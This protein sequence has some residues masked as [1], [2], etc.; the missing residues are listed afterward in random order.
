M[1]FVG[2]EDLLARLLTGLEQGQR[3]RT[4]DVAGATGMGKSTLLQEAQRRSAARSTGM[5]VASVDLARYN[6]EARGRG[7]V[8]QTY[9]QA[10]KHYNEVRALAS[11]LLHDLDPERA[12]VLEET[13]QEF[14]RNRQKMKVGKVNVYSEMTAG[15]GALISA[16]PQ[17]IKVNF[18]QNAAQDAVLV[19]AAR[20]A[21]LQL[22]NILAA[23]L[24]DISSSQ[25][26]LLLFDNV[27]IVAGQELG[28]WISHLISNLKG[29]V[30]VL[31]HEP[32]SVLD[33]P[34]GTGDALQISPF[35]L[36]EVSEF[37]TQ[38]LG[39]ERISDDLVA[40]LYKWS[41][42]VPIALQV[43]VDLM[44]DPTIKLCR[45]DLEKRLLR[46][47]GNAE[48]RLAGVVT[49]MVERLEG[50]PLGKALR[51]ASI[52]AECDIKLLAA[53][54][55]D[56]GVTPES[57]IPL[58]KDLEAFSFTDE[59]KSPIDK[60]D[61]VKVH[62]F[63]RQGIAD[64]MLKY[65]PHE[66]NHLHSVAAEYFYGQFT[67]SNSYFEMFGFEKPDQQ[68]WLRKW[69]Y[70]VAHSEDRRTAMLQ[71][72]RV[73]FDAFWWWGNYVNF[74]FC[75]ILITDFEGL[76]SETQDDN[77]VAFADAVR[78]F[79]DNYPYR[80]KLRQDFDRTY[81]AAPWNEVE[82]ALFE[83]RELCGLTHPSTDLSERE[84]H[85]EALLQV[86]LAHAS[87]YGSP[88]DPLESK[89][90][91]DEAARHFALVDRSWDVP[92]VVFERGDLALESGD[93]KL[94][95]DEATYAASLLYDD[96]DEK[97]PD[98]E[99]IANIHRLRADCAWLDG[100]TD[101]AAK[102]Y[103]LAVVHSFLFHRIGGPPD[104]YTMQFYFEARG[105]AIEK[106]LVL[107]RSGRS[108]ESVRFG[109]IM[110]ESFPTMPSLPKR[111]ETELIEVCR[112]GTVAELANMLFPRGPDIGELNQQSTPFMKMLL[113]IE[114]RVQASL[115]G[116][117][118]RPRSS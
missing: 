56:D 2:R 33:A 76:A 63:I 20:E 50:R 14:T 48:G 18:D 35:S 109:Q 93:T 111:S 89:R 4:T 79:R 43:L 7:G 13:D 59:Y 51:A 62:A 6:P 83:I 30:V 41:G 115:R 66:R 100:K 32:N 67:G 96:F 116:D 40:L 74:D 49:E 12:I 69:L 117:L 55:A 53:L 85:T 10:L 73:F 71:A 19:G 102:E 22:S 80:A 60:I 91:Y 58:M 25:P 29:A 15:A 61:Y 87:R 36:D 26:M 57:A 104:D 27:D 9:G 118:L 101:L 105:R 42:G 21:T 47:P 17:T 97:N 24:N 112:N 34:R 95:L 44:N 86:F 75:E 106:M 65:A 78:R 23:S 77:L 1:P 99:L 110:Q 37:L 39:Q 72:A 98:E 107:W 64:G 88:G 11:D 90:H 5:V 82:D 31:A 114:D 84:R 68:S 28:F 81:P 46:L 108:A 113:R 54:L 16:S 8:D 3:L 70:H 103:G 94:A 38:T 92:W 52:P 45:E